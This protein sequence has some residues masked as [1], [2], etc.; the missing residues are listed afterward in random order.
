MG[1]KR[2]ERTEN[3][4]LVVQ[5]APA[6]DTKNVG[7]VCRARRPTVCVHVCVCVCVWLVNLS[8]NVKGVQWVRVSCGDVEHK[9]Q[10]LE[11]MRPQAVCVHLTHS[12]RLSISCSHSLVLYNPGP[13]MES[14]VHLV[15]R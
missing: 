1:R 8:H 10:G 6:A 5:T 14:R 12:L 9:P 13:V 4:S 7:I 15:F 2:V 11:W 3:I